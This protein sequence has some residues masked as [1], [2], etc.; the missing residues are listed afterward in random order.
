MKRC[1][2]SYDEWKCIEKKEQ[3]GRRFHTED[4]SGYIGLM[5][6]KK[7]SEPQTWKYSG[8]D[9]V[10]CDDGCKWLSILPGEEN[11]CITVMMGSE[12]EI[13]LWY[14]DMIA[15]QGMD[16][17]GIPYFMD[18]YLDLVVY[19]DGTII[20]D[21]MDELEEA[22]SN[23]D[24]TQQQYAMAVSTSDKLI[25]QSLSYLTGLT[26]RCL[27]LLSEEFPGEIFW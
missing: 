22:L 9:M 18:L 2:L 11:F 26:N 1:R 10:V 20:I 23:G 16:E 24:I 14:I 15:G 25:K 8:T 27:E 19:P 5:K 7:V 17:D 6:I 12:S 3:C 13:L 21:D 4:W